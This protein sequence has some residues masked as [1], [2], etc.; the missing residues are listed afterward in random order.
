MTVMKACHNSPS[1]AAAAVFA[2]ADALIEDVG[3]PDAHA[4]ALFLASLVLEECPR[5]V[6]NGDVVEALMAT[7]V[8]PGVTSASAAVRR[9]AVRCLG[10]VGIVFGVRDDGECVGV[11]RAALCGD[12]PAVRAVAARA[13][14]DLSLLYGAQ[15]L[16][17]HNPRGMNANQRRRRSRRPSRR[18]SWTPST[19]STATPPSPRRAPKTRKRS[20][21]LTCSPAARPRLR[22]SA[23]RPW[24][25]PPVRL[26]QS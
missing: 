26:W 12:C 9:E 15:A 11:L 5:H 1:D 25:P 7:L 21:R 22:L 19:R 13:L 23:T 14:G 20:T 16:D 18:R 2:C 4:Q 10:L 6:V 3:T 17:A 24:Q 8:R